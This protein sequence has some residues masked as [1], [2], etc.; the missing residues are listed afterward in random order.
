MVGSVQ[1]PRLHLV[2]RQRGK[3]HLIGRGLPVDK[4][5]RQG[6]GEHFLRMQ[7]GCLD[8]IPKHIV[9][10]DLKALHPGLR[11][12]VALHGGNNRAPLVAQLAGI[13]QLRVIAAGDKS[14]VPR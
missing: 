1:N 9:V 3:A 12:K 6:G 14:A 2:E 7:G 10:L 11:D 13:I 8:K 4:G 5:F